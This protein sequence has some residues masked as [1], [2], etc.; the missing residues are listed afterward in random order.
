MI[1]LLWLRSQKRL[2]D[3]ISVDLG[4]ESHDVLISQSRS[5]HLLH[6]I[7]NVLCTIVLHLALSEGSSDLG[8]FTLDW[9]SIL[10]RLLFDDRSIRAFFGDNATE[11][12]FFNQSLVCRQN[13][14]V[15]F[16]VLVFLEFLNDFKLYICLKLPKVGFWVATHNSELFLFVFLFASFSEILLMKN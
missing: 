13:S 14:F 1:W 11:L 7:E 10:T 9:S 4:H 15:L 12:V 2:R 6:R 3:R 5:F 16:S 8:W